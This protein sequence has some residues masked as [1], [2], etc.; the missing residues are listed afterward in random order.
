MG[1]GSQPEP[2]RASSQDMVPESTNEEQ[3]E[4]PATGGA[5]GSEQQQQ[6]EREQ[7]Q[8]PRQPPPSAA[9]RGPAPRAARQTPSVTRAFLWDVPS[10][11]Y[12]QLKRKR[13]C[14]C[15][16][17]HQRFVVQTVVE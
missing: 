8:P 9:P 6:F 12:S 17:L 7:P 5:S 13:K 15:V 11:W 4:L 3:E 10:P 14:C 1:T 16:G 2:N